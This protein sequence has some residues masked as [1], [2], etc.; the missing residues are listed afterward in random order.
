M[1]DT[2]VKNGATFLNYHSLDE[3]KEIANNVQAQGL[4]FGLAGSINLQHVTMV[5]AI[6]PDYNGF[7]CGLCINNIRRSALDAGKIIAIRELV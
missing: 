4:R 7:I 1:F 2:A 5:K 3:M 6:E